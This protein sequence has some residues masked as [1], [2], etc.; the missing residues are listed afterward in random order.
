MLHRERG[1]TMFYLLYEPSVEECN[2]EEFVLFHTDAEEELAKEFI[3][4]YFYNYQIL[5]VF[6]TFT[7]FDT[8]I[9]RYVKAT[10]EDI[11]KRFDRRELQEKT[12]KEFYEKKATYLA[13]FKEPI[14]A[15]KED[16]EKLEKE[17]NQKIYQYIPHKDLTKELIQTLKS[18]GFKRSKSKY[19]MARFRH[20]DFVAIRK[21][22]E[23]K[24]EKIKQEI[25]KLDEIKWQKAD[26]FD[27]NNPLES[28]DDVRAYR[29][30]FY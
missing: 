15:L 10:K 20:E 27:Q 17:M 2:G 29:R 5:G 14:N 30:T 13:P 11:Q 6:P 25:N 4:Y 19:D 26:E 7:F 28:F 9:A 18:Q 16:L 21:E 23:K 1:K 24:K 22:Y 3:L 8:K 12:E